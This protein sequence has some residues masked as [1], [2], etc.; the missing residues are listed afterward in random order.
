M[1]LGIP[2]NRPPAKEPEA[3]SEGEDGAIGDVV[4]PEGEEEGKAKNEPDQPDENP[5][6]DKKN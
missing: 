4:K 3:P 6:D 5:L 2:D 1:L